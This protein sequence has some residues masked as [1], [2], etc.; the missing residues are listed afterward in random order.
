MTPRNRRFITVD[1][2]AALDLVVSL[3]ECLPPDH[4]ARFVVDTIDQLELSCIYVHYGARGGKA[5]APEILLG[6]L[7]YGYA[8]GVFSSRKIEK[9]T[10]ESIPFRYIAGGLHPDHDT[11]ADFRKTFLPEIGELFVQILLVAH[12]AGV[13]KLGHI[14]LDGSKIHADASKSKA[15]SYKRLLELEAQ[16]RQEVVELLALGEQADRIELPEGLVIEDEITFRKN[17]LANLAEAK[18]VLEARAQERYEA[19]QA[20]YEAK[21][22][23]REEKARQ[24]GRKPRG[25]TPQPPTPGPRDKDQYNFTDPESRMMKNSNNQGFDQHYNTQVVVDQDSFLIVANTLSNHPNDYAEMEPT[26]DTIPAE[27]GTP[28]AA[29]MDNG[30]FSA[31]NITA[32]EARGIDPYIAT[33][34]KPHHR[35]WKAYFAELP[36]PPSEDASPTVKMAYKLQTEIG[37]AIY[38]LRKCTVEPVIGVIKE[39]LGFRQFSLRGLAAAAGEWCL[40]CLAFNLKRLHVLLMAG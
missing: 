40:V 37:K 4:L 27:L 15:V 32:C 34:R 5:Y 36:A 3:R 19:E 11:I 18:A 26:L 1:Y 22:R 24:T 31:D 28:D 10:Y 38:G 8:T 25:R 29:A 39:V 12:T 13:L 23:A 2:E 9:A 30:Y 17:R 33:G 14:S 16:F 35:S 21:M 20:E 7:F 6:L